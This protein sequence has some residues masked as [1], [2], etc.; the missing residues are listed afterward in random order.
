[1]PAPTIPA[2]VPLSLLEAL[3]NLDTPLEDGLPELSPEVVAKRLGLSGTVA[4]Q[5]ERYQEG[6]ER[7]EPVPR[8]EAVG[9]FRLVGRR[10]DAA[11]A[12][13]DAGRRAARHAARGAGSAHA[14]ARV[15]PAGFT[16]TLGLRA[17]R[18]VASKRF[19]AELRA[20][21][22]VIEARIA[23]SLS[24]E[25]LPD[26]GACTYFG[27]LFAELLRCL[28]GFEG[29]MTHDRCRARG[30]Q[31]CAWRWAEAEGYR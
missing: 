18:K 22:A 26:G 5:I 12:F 9:V 17:A 21:G 2:L 3:R 29:A 28:G 6:M 24:I 7:E 30:D 11:L 4:A 20:A 23:S 10:P 14:L 13:A 1:M 25:A 16:R 19:E 8:A 27:A 31:L 15:A